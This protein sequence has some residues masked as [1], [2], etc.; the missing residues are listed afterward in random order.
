MFA[1][2]LFSFSNLARQVKPISICVMT[3]IQTMHELAPQK[4]IITGADNKNNIE[5][6]YFCLFILYNTR[7]NNIS[8]SQLCFLFF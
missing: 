8:L 4:Y 1:R 2:S 7:Y 6:V 5:I 3:T